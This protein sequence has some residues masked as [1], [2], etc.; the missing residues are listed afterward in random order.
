MIN[1]TRDI[2]I[3]VD[4][5][6][7]CGKSSFARLIAKEMQYL[8][9]DSGAMYRAVALFG[10]RNELITGEEIREDELVARLPEI[11]ITFERKGDDYLTLLN[12]EDVEMAIRGVEVSSIVSQVSKIAE[13]RKYLVDLQQKMGGQ[14]RIVMDGRDIGTVVFPEAEC[15]I[16]MKANV[17]VRAQRRFDE[18]KAKGIEASL[19]TITRNIE[20]RDY[21]DLHR[22]VSPLRM[23]HDARVLDNSYMTFEEQMEWFTELLNRKKLLAKID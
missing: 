23:A 12:G 20:D 15:K 1:T 3:A 10:I 18:L 8:Y 22:E 9:L 5:F 6:S 2:I 11:R 13:V 21:H 16:F 7:S 4:G 19:E 14:K 17:C